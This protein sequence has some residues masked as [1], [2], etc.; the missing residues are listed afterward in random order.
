MSPKRKEKKKKKTC[1][2]NEERERES[3]CVCVCVCGIDERRV[4]A[5]QTLTFFGGER[6][7]RRGKK[8]KYSR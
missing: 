3:V 8:N 2:A 7:K 5:P 1:E 4:N 6:E